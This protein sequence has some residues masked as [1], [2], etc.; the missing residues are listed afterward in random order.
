MQEKPSPKTIGHIDPLCALLGYWRCL[1]VLAQSQPGQMTLYAEQFLT[2]D[3]PRS[4]IVEGLFYKA[5][6]AT[7]AMTKLIKG[8]TDAGF[9][10][11]KVG[12]A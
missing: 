7:P 6:K 8:F 9:I 5:G 3:K 11:S 1:H 10:L 2:A 12:L 4:Q